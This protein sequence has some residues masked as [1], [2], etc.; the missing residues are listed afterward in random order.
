VLQGYDWPGN[1]RELEHAV[2]C[3]VIVCSGSAIRAEDIA[4]GSGQVAAA[5]PEELLTLEA[6]ERRYIRRVLEQT[7]WRIR[8]PGGAAAILGLH[9]ATLR[10]RMKK[11]GIQRPDA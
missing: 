10:G 6:F 4:L 11:L 3:A 8:G 2:Q 9:E 5:P 7:G 1:V